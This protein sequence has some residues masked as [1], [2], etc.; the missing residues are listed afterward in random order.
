MALPSATHFRNGAFLPRTIMQIQISILPSPRRANNRPISTTPMGDSSRMFNPQCLNVISRH[1][2]MSCP[3]SFK[4]IPPAIQYAA[5]V[6]ENCSRFRRHRLIHRTHP[7]RSLPSS[8]NRFA[9]D[10]QHPRS[11][12][13]RRHRQYMP[14]RHLPLSLIYIL[15]PRHVK[16]FQHRRIQSGLEISTQHRDPDNHRAHRLAH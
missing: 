12:Q 7:H 5:A 10:H 11:S 16:I 4:K 2:S 3:V 13:S 1:E 14:Q 6:I 8:W 15:H 9:P